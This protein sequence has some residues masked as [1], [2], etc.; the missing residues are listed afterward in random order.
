MVG[1][2]KAVDNALRVQL[3]WGLGNPLLFVSFNEKCNPFKIDPWLPKY[4]FKMFACK[5]CKVEHTNTWLNWWTN[6]VLYPE[7]KK[8]IDRA[9]L[10]DKGRY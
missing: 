2:I 8:G 9:D 10:P 5:Y 6:A 1:C 7:R 4:L 3:S